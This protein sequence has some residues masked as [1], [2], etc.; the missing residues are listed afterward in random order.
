[1]VETEPQAS[2]EIPTQERTLPT[3]PTNTSASIQLT[4]HTALLR[5]APVPNEIRT[6][7]VVSPIMVTTATTTIQ[8]TTAPQPVWQ[9]APSPISRGGSAYSD[10][11]RPLTPIGG[12]GGGGG[13]GGNGGGGGGGRG[14]G[15]GGG[16]FPPLQPLPPLGAPG[17]QAR[18]VKPMG[19]LPPIFDGDRTKS[20]GFIDLL[21]SYFGLNHRVPAFQSYLTRIA[22][23]LTLIQGPLVQEWTRH[24]GNWL[25]C[26]HPML[27][28]ILDT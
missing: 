9:R 25:D 14:G 6:S 10:G 26:P 13:G 1:L 22:L 24:L 11:R 27:D 17:G 23:A 15:G 19:Q 16:G 18:D 8:T 7:P 2:T 4:H 12:G 20:K 28:D 5:L 21:K 3:S